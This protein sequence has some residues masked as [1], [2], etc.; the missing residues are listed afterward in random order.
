MLA[1]VR[2]RG[3]DQPFA[4]WRL[5][6]SPRAPAPARREIPDEELPY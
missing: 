6:A 5:D 2:R 3:L 4:G 1:D